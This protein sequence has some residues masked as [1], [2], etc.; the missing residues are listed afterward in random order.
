[1]MTNKNIQVQIDEVNQKLDL[2]LH[3]VNEQRLKSERMEDLV[4]DV[5]IIGKDLFNTTVHELDNQGIELDIEEMK[6]LVFKL[7]KNAGNFTKVLEMFENVTDFLKDAGPVAREVIIDLIN[8]LHEFEQKGYFEFFKELYRVMDNIIVNY[9]E[10]DVRLLADNIVTI[11]DT[12]K[13]LTQPE[14]LLAMNN[15]ITIYKNLGMEN[16]EEYSLFRALRE[17]RSPEMK[18]GIGF[19]IAFLKNLSEDK[20][21]IKKK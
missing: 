20:K 8:K 13:N 6:I 21:E 3:Y 4:T 15:A 18:R 19:I 2:V 1:M 11:L 7:I 14:M 10:E 9:S 16:I 12:V 5:S 17:M